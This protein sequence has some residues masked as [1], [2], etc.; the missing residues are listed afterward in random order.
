MQQILLIVQNFYIYVYVL[1][2]LDLQSS[3]FSLF[4]AQSKQVFFFT[5]D[6]K[7]LAYFLDLCH[8]LIVSSHKEYLV[9]F[10]IYCKNC[11][12]FFSLNIAV[13]KVALEKNTLWNYLFMA[14]HIIINYRMDVLLDQ[15][16]LIFKRPKGQWKLQLPS[17]P[18]LFQGPAHGQF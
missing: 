7:Y 5:N 6:V 8:G 12:A 10:I 14:Q 11:T 1:S 2:F 4:L 13:S 3:Y 15:L 16:N 17:L 9:Q 18:P